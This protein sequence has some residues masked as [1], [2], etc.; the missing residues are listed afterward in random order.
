M[1]SLAVG[2]LIRVSTTSGSW[3]ERRER[4]EEQGGGQEKWSRGRRRGRRRGE[5]DVH[6]LTRPPG[7]KC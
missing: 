7:R 2:D 5:G 1:K 3:R 4:W 6:G